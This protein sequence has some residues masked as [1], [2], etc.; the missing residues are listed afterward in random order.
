MADNT[1]AADAIPVR[2]DSRHR[3][4]L[5]QFGPTSDVYLVTRGERG[6]LILRPGV[7]MPADEFQEL[8]HKYRE[9]TEKLAA[10]EDL[11]PATMAA[12]TGMVARGRANGEPDDEPLVQAGFGSSIELGSG[13]DGGYTPA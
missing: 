3:L 11:D 7:V 9:A 4:N 2:L 13:S 6:M 5:G 12:R 10:E 1:Q 8:V